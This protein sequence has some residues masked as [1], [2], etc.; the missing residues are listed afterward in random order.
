MADLDNDGGRECYLGG[1]VGKRKW[2]EGKTL[3]KEAVLRRL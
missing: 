1:R 3:G 2:E